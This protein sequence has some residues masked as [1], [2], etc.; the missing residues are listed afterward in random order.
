MNKGAIYIG[1][2]G[3]NYKGW[4]GIIYPDDTLS[5]QWFGYYTQIFKTV[6]INNTFYKL[7]KVET[8]RHWRDQAPDGFI[9]TVKANRFITHMKKLKD[10]LTSL[11]RFFTCVY[12][13]ENHLGPILY[14]LPPHW[15]L[16]LERLKNFLDFLPNDLTHV[17]E[18]RDQSWMVDEVFELLDKKGAAFCTHD[19]R[20][21][22]IPRLS[23][24]PI[25]YVRFHGTGDVYTGGYPES[26]LLNWWNWMESEVNKGKD[27]YV[28]FNNDVGGQ[29]VRDAK[30]LM[31]ISR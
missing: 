7:P 10:P 15:K 13:L 6:E 5:S 28:Y 1:C 8:F 17:F 18:F 20:C 31:E 4:Q 16:N 24:G 3:W 21:L 27:L 22:N 30:V 25:T 9:Y 26:T 2:S 29:A 11:Q 14:Q 12:T 23:T 19:M